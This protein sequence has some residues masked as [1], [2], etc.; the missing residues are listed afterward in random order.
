MFDLKTRKTSGSQFK[1]WLDDN[2]RW[3]ES[4]KYKKAD[5]AR[6]EQ[7]SHTP[8]IW[9]RTDM[10]A[11]N[12][13]NSNQSS[14][15]A[16]RN[17]ALKSLARQAVQLAGLVGAAPTSESD[18]ESEGEGDDEVD[19]ESGR[20][21]G[22]GIKNGDDGK[23]RRA[24]LPPPPLSPLPGDEQERD[25]LYRPP[26]A[27]R[28]T[29][30]GLPPPPTERIPG[31]NSVRGSGDRGRGR[32]D[33]N[34]EEEEEEEEDFEFD[35]SDDENDR[36]QRDIYEYVQGAGPGPEGGGM[37]RIEGEVGVV[38]EVEAGEERGREQTRPS[39]VRHLLMCSIAWRR[40]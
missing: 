12:Y 16:H 24:D 8:N 23:R 31:Q 2:K 5:T 37:R 13:S 29:S 27:T 21:R 19:E 35:V 1:S 18:S 22:S 36:I 17:L 7:H 32:S 9:G 3:R 6:E 33:E 25:S 14:Y 11:T 20:G 4:I 34:E 10:N 28:A 40:E 39:V 15:G 26:S 38:V 30:S